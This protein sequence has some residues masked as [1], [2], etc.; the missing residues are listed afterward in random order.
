MRLRAAENRFKD[1]EKARAKLE[2]QVRH[3]RA[4]GDRAAQVQQ[5][6]EELRAP[7]LVQEPAADACF[8]LNA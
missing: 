1:S 8:S 7:T 5:A 3:M 2:R 6:T 4:C